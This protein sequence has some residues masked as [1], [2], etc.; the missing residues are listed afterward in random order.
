MGADRP[1]F[2]HRSHE[3]EARVTACLAPWAEL[4]LPR[5]PLLRRAASQSM[6]SMLELNNRGIARYA[7]G[8]IVSSSLCAEF[9]CQHYGVPD[10]RVAVIA[11]APPDQFSHEPEGGWGDNRLN[12][13]LYVGQFAFVKGPHM[14]S[15]AFDHVLSHRPE[16]TLTWVCDARH[17][18]QAAMLL[19]P[20][21]RARVQ[22]LDW[23]P[24]R[25]LMA[26]YDAH[27]VFLFPSLFEG[28]G[29]ALVEAM[30]R[31]LVVVAS[32]EGGAKDL[33]RDGVNG[34]VVPVG[35]AAALA[36]ACLFAQED[37][38]LAR[39]VSEHARAAAL[40]HTWE[41]LALETVDFYGRLREAR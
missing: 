17:H 15:Q 8:H 21:A 27:G 33:I 29:K 34:F 12:R 39:R 6:Q 38:A 10:G 7:D 37:A 32:A 19:K 13:L 35:D 4:L 25:E 22:F 41:R 20:A 30:A 11:Q 31:G 9:M 26:I 14:L 16:A 18:E 23:V 5:R 40:E 28:F 1:V 2:V 24:Q 3:L 36:K